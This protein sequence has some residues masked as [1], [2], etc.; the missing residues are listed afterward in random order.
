MVGATGIQAS[1]IVVKY[2]VVKSVKKRW[3]FPQR[4]LQPTFYQPLKISMDVKTSMQKTWSNG[5]LLTRVSSK[6]L[7]RMKTSSEPSQMGFKT[8]MMATT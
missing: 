7:C 4:Y 1:E 3:S 6:R 2:L 5:W 8:M